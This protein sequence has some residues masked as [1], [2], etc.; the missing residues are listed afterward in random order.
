M[1]KKLVTF[2]LGTRP[3]AIKLAPL[4]KLFVNN[5][6]FETRVISTGQHTE[7]VDKI[8]NLFE[9]KIDKNLNIMKEKQLLNNILSNSLHGLNRDIIDYK[10][11]LIFVQGDTTTSLAGALAGFH[12]NIPIAHVEAGLR[13]DDIFNPFPEEANRRIISQIASLNFAPTVKSEKLLK[14]LK[15]PGKIYLTGNTVIDALEI[16]SK[17]LKPIK[18]E[19]LD[20]KKNKVILTTIHRRENWGDN[21]KNIAHGIYEILEKNSDAAVL[22]PMHPNILIRDVLK[23]ILENHK[24]AFLIE[25]LEYDE[26]IFAMKNSKFLLTDSGGLQEEAPTFKKPVL[27]LRKNTERKEAITA[28]TAKLIGTNSKN[29]VKESNQ[30]LNDS[31]YY[32]KMTKDKNPFGDGLASQRI[33][34]ICEEFL[35]S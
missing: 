6:F 13:T 35:N 24:R 17:K 26:F 34:N 30:L 11:N 31:S 5:S 15:V 8:V 33:L 28:G 16:C 20:W 22:L 9:I 21:L 7:M 19:G 27:I 32:N 23:E 29:I 4:I 25:P 2:I 10:P 18:I 14:N 1:A 12:H 3:E